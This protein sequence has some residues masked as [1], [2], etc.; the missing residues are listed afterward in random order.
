M[1]NH[2]RVNRDDIYVLTTLS[3]K[4]AFNTFDKWKTTAKKKLTMEIWEN[5]ELIKVL[6]I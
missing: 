3:I 5:N 2:Y 1:S 4:D 6:S